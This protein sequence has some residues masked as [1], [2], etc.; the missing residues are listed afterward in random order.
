MAKIRT[1][2][3]PLSVASIIR[4]TINA[5][6][7]CC[8]A[9]RRIA[10]TKEYYAHEVVVE[11]G[12]SYDN[13]VLIADGLARLTHVKA[14]KEDTIC[15]GS[16]G[17]IFAS[18]HSIWAHE[19]AVY[20]VEALVD[21]TCHIV[22]MSKFRRLEEKYPELTRWWALV[23]TEQIYCLEVLYRKMT[24][25]S[26]EERL[27]SFW[28]FSNQKLSNMNPAMLSRVVPLKVIAQYLGMTPQTLSKVRRK[29]VGLE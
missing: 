12:K 6:D 9:L 21:M 1:K 19:P 24:M 8:D 29:L 13:I 16:A 2:Q 7:A 28:D 18:F 26:P 20:G 4:Q 25:A 27:K 23:L 22:P 14:G 17:D 11:Q 15:F 10:V 3:D 5:S